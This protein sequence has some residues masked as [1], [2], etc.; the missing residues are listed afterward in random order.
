[1][2]KK[3][4]LIILSLCLVGCQNKEL[5]ININKTDDFE[6]KTYFS[7]NKEQLIIDVYN[8]SEDIKSL[9]AEINLKY[10]NNDYIEN[11]QWNNLNSNENA[12]LYLDLSEIE[13]LQL[14][15]IN[16][17]EIPNQLDWD[18]QEIKNN[19]ETSY[20]VF[21]DFSVDVNI[22]NK[23]NIYLAEV[24]ANVVFYQNN[25]PVYAEKIYA[26]DFEENYI[27]TIDIPKINGN[28]I[29]CDDIKVY[30]DNIIFNYNDENKYLIESGDSNEN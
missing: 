13:E 17:T 19:L 25:I 6:T 4:W 9:N 10:S 26:M 23:L 20:E 5:K 12:V 29:D 18:K 2:M 21:D 24:S 27:K 15:E 14:V 8:K 1:M 7:Y 11:L 30:Y 28:I 22:N 3:V 16:V